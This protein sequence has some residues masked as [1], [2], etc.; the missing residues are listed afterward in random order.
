M[1]HKISQRKLSRSTN[2]R[3]ALFK[4]LISALIIHGEIKTT[5]AKAK[6]VKP[7]FEKLITKGKKNTV[8]S[9]RLIAKTLAK[10]DLVNKLVDEISPLFK[11]R[12]GGFTRIIKLE[13]RAVDNATIVKLE[14]VE[15]PKPRIKKE[16][17]KEEKS[18]VKSLKKQEKPLKKEEKKITTKKKDA[19]NKKS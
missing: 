13:K 17:P 10:K 1:R 18:K 8:Y 19:K 4:N 11:S 5:E 15:K 12:P 3:K 7:I 14:L 9:R 2:H 6:A 16:K